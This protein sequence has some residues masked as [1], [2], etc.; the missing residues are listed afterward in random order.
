MMKVIPLHIP[1][2]RSSG[3]LPGAVILKSSQEGLITEK[4]FNTKNFVEFFH[5]PARDPYPLPVKKYILT[6][7]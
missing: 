5:Q 7:I 1:I 3:L 6:V 4:P 2:Y